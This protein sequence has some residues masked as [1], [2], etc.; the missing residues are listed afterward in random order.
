[1]KIETKKRSGS[2]KR[3]DGSNNATTMRHTRN[4]SCLGALNDATVSVDTSRSIATLFSGAFVGAIVG[5]MVGG[6][7]AAR[8]LVNTGACVRFTTQT[9]GFVLCD[10][11]G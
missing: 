11:A 8:A 7:V 9:Q 3:A 10:S 1:M 5:E 6:G 2:E 4:C